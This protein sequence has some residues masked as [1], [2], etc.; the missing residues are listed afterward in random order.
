M[1][2]KKD[3]FKLIARKGYHSQEM[4]R[5]LQQKGHPPEEIQE[6]IQDLIRLGYLND[7]EYMAAFQRKAEKGAGMLTWMRGKLYQKGII[8]NDSLIDD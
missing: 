8:L 5:K 4:A 7:E 6:A 3:A 1:S 2:C